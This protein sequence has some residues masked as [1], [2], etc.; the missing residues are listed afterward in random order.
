MIQLPVPAR[1]AVSSRP[2]LPSA[3]RR[4]QGF[5]LIEV[6]IV[7]GIV[8]IL[9]GLA[10]PAYS[11]YIRRGQ[12]QEAFS[13][14]SDYRVKMEQFYQDNRNYG[15]AATCAQVGGAT[16]SWGSFA[17]GSRYFTF[18]CALTNAGQGYTITATGSTGRATGHAFTVDATNARRTT[19]FKGVA[20]TKTCWLVKG[21]EC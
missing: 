6:M 19:Q 7:V 11:D 14:M 1:V 9:A 4:L 20:S 3:P 18:A 21:D 16:P 13:F 17:P 15:S 8:A 10:V 2:K 5:T 12:L